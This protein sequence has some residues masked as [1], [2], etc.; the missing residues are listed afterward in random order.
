VILIRG[1]YVLWL[2]RSLEDFGSMR[3]GFGGN[4]QVFINIDTDGFPDRF[5]MAI[6]LEVMG[7][8]FSL[9]NDV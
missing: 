1:D 7:F 5:V 8:S 4:S 6:P 9:K 2:N 3:G